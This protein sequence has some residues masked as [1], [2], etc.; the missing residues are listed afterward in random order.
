MTELTVD[1]F[2]AQAREWLDANSGQMPQ[3]PPTHLLVQLAH[4]MHAAL[5]TAAPQALRVCRYSVDQNG[6][7]RIDNAEHPAAYLDVDAPL[8]NQNFLI[9]PML[10]GCPLDTPS[11]FMTGTY[12]MV[13]DGGD[14]F[15]IR[16]PTFSLDLPEPRL[17]E[18]VAAARRFALLHA[19]AED[20]AAQPGVPIHLLA[21]SMGGLVARVALF[22]PDQADAFA[23]APAAPVNQAAAS[24]T[25]LP[26][27]AAKRGSKPGTANASTTVITS[28]DMSITLTDAPDPV[29]AG[30]KMDA[31]MPAPLGTLPLPRDPTTGLVR[32]VEVDPGA[33]YHEASPVA[34]APSLYAAFTY[35]DRKGY[36]WV[37]RGPM[38][39]GTPALG[40][41]FYYNMQAPFDFPSGLN[42][43]R[44]AVGQPLPY[45]RPRND[46][47]TYAGDPVSGT[48]ATILY[49]PAWP[50][51]PP[52][53]SVAETL[54]LSK[55]GLPAVRGQTSAR[56]LYQQ[57]IALSGTAAPSVTL[58][59]PT[60]AKTVLLNSA[61]VGLTALPSSLKT[62][63]QNGKTYFQ[64]APPHLQQ[65]FYLNPLL[66][67]IG[68]LE[69]DGQFVD[70]IAGEDYLNLNA[71][72]P[73][74][75]ASLKNLVISADADKSKWDLAIAAL[76]TRVETF[77]EDP[78]KP[79]T[80]IVDSQKSVNVG[81]ASLPEVSYSDTAVDSYALSAT[82]KGAGYVTLLFSDGEAFTPPGNG[83][84]MQVIKVIP[85]LYQGD[86]KKLLPSN[87]L[88]EQV[89]LR[90]SGDYA[91]RPEDYEFQWRWATGAASATLAI[92]HNASG[93][94]LMVALTGSGTV[95]AAPVAQLSPASLSWSQVINTASAAQLATLSNTG[96][97]PLAISTIALTGAAAADYTIASGS[98]CAAGGSVAAGA[99]VAVLA[100][101]SVARPSTTS[102]PPTSVELDR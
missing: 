84:D 52:T 45:L 85:K 38:N 70:E 60:R 9:V 99:S 16:I 63:S 73:A 11:G 50:A 57:S 62:T 12:Q 17:E 92:A 31:I 53:L 23:D 58:H 61:A 5:G 34:G 43:V 44:P 75:T 4:D 68:G 96:N 33:S 98:T 64:L 15:D 21:H 71:L 94:P 102:W 79:G 49:F 42:V 47:G 6:N 67:D 30:T 41:N 78:A 27:G 86:L 59:D 10:A 24:N 87:P 13:S 100:S 2:Q 93:S 36:D 25:G 1:D 72:S 51:N 14:R 90:H 74:D 19:A 28:A 29:T 97:A 80:Y 18:T 55:N 82:G 66:G 40:M 35:K 88:D 7:G 56:V 32:N 22:G 77:K 48:P 65:R 20:V 8:G 76:S 101:S 54:A 3:D 37:Y 39:G 69:L 95:P 89:T 91:G 26:P 46:D 83:V 81:A